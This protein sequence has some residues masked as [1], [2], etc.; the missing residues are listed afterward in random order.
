MYWRHPEY[1]YELQIGLE[2][3]SLK[4]PSCHLLRKYCWPL[5]NGWGAIGVLY[6]PHPPPHNWQ[7]M[8][9]LD[10]QLSEYLVPMT[11]WFR[12]SGFTQPGLGNTVVFTIKKKSVHKWFWAVQSCA[13]QGL[14]VFRTKVLIFKQNPVNSLEE[15]PS[16]FLL[17]QLLCTFYSANSKLKSFF[18]FYYNSDW[19]TSWSTREFGWYIYIYI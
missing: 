15:E 13:I 12:I 9:D 2:Q 11:P 16:F 19:I 4:I 3:Y 8:Y 14:T 1:F 10:C 5:N 17:L 18:F 6:A 7:S